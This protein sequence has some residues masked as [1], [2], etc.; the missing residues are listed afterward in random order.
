MRYKHVRSH[1]DISEKL[2]TGKGESLFVKVSIMGN[3]YVTKK[4]T[5]IF[6]VEMRNT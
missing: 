3:F 4:N 1:R 6:F 5:Q 2:H